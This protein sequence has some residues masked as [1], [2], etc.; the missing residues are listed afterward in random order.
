MGGT[1]EGYF[2]D[3]DELVFKVKYSLFGTGRG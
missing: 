1:I 3:V 2:L